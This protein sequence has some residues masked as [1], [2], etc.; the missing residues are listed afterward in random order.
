MYIKIKQDDLEAEFNSDDIT[1]E[2]P[3]RMIKLGLQAMGFHSDTVNQYFI[4]PEDLSEYE[5]G[6]ADAKADK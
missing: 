1:L 6:W 4:D 5:K 3:V 2:E